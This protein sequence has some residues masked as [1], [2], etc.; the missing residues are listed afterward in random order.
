M[1]K[2]RR[3]KRRI[4]KVGRPA[5]DAKRNGLLGRA[6]TP[7]L[8]RRRKKRGLSIA[9]VA[10]LTRMSFVTIWRIEQGTQRAPQET[11][12]KIRKALQSK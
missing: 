1:K 5:K 8:E 7:D 11:L 9:R 12:E 10:Q 6:R 4:R 2:K 3:P